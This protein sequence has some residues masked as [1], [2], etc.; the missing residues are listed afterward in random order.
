MG[1]VNKQMGKAG[2]KLISKS[3]WQKTFT[4]NGTSGGGPSTTTT[5]TDSS[6][7]SNISSPT[8]RNTQYASIGTSDSQEEPSSPTTNNQPEAP[9]LP[10]SDPQK[11][12]LARVHFILEQQDVPPSNSYLPPYHVLYSNSEC[13]AVWC[14][15]GTFS[16]LQ[17]AVFLHSTAVGNAKSTFLL[18]ASL[19]ATQPWL[20]PVI[21]MYGLVAVGMPYYILK[22]CHKKW[23]EFETKL[24]DGF[25][26]TCENEVIVEAIEK[27]SD[28]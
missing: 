20:I 6:K 13:L 27:W 7:A 3:F 28:L 9:K 14:K 19:G 16:T 10:K 21:G 8:Q 15:T 11:I 22:K 12:V 17:A 18:T 5:T 26:G 24:T 1:Q 23:K 25:W 4:I 2:K